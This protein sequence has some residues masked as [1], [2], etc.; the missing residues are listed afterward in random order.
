MLLLNLKKQNLF[1]LSFLK[2][3]ETQSRVGLLSIERCSVPTSIF[4]VPCGIGLLRSLDQ[5]PTF[6]S[7]CCQGCEISARVLF[8]CLFFFFKCEGTYF[9]FCFPSISPGPSSFFFCL[10]APLLF[11]VTKHDLHSHCGYMRSL[12]NTGSD[13]SILIVHSLP[14]PWKFCLKSFSALLLFWFFAALSWFLPN[15]LY[16][17]PV[18]VK[19]HLYLSLGSL[20]FR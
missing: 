3:V 14:Y 18:F 12:L 7:L 2:L 5:L 10:T 19:C 1:F 9:L 6:L 8:L 11:R 13:S 20:E 17:L 4:A 15:C 16:C